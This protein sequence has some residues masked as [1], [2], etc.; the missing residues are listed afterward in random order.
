MVNRRGLVAR[1]PIGDSALAGV[2]ETL[3][4]ADA[5]LVEGANA[6]RQTFTRDQ[7]IEQMAARAAAA[8]GK[9]KDEE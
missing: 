4:A 1:P 9:E 7:F 3:E 6:P 8:A 2:E 5:F